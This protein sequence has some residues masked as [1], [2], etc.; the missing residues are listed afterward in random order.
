METKHCVDSLKVKVKLKPRPRALPGGEDPMSSRHG[1]RMKSC[2]WRR[3]S[4]SIT[5]S[6]GPCTPNE[7][8]AM[9]TE[10]EVDVLLKKLGGCL[11]PDGSSVDQRRCC[12]CNQ[13]GDGRTDGPARLLN[14]DLDL[15]VSLD[16]QH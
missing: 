3:W 6:R 12:F 10:E 15:W 7:G 2:S 1:K 5:L 11:G 9:P 14:L 8:R 4:F 16:P 13:Q